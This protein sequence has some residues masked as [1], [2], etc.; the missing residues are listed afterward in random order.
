MRNSHDVIG[1]IGGG[2]TSSVFDKNSKSGATLPDSNALKNSSPIAT[3]QTNKWLSGNKSI[4]GDLNCSFEIENPEVNFKGNNVALVKNF[5]NKNI[6][7]KKMLKNTR[8]ETAKRFDGK[9]HAA[10][11]KVE[12]KAKDKKDAKKGGKANINTKEETP[13]EEQTVDEVEVVKD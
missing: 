4:Q 6:N 11:A 13:R 2:T 10:P 1:K 7:I 12:E 3:R 8:I 5:L 9:K